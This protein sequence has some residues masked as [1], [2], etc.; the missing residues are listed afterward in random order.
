MKKIIRLTERDLTRIVRRVLNE[1]PMTNP[2]EE[3]PT[4]PMQEIPSNIPNSIHSDID[5]LYEKRDELAKEF[6][7]LE[8]RSGGLM[9]RLK[10]KVGDKMGELEDSAK[11][12]IEEIRVNVLMILDDI[13][14]KLQSL[15]LNAKKRKEE[16]M[17]R[18]HKERLEREIDIYEKSIQDIKDKKIITA[19]DLQNLKDI[20]SI[21]GIYITMIGSIIARFIYMHN[22]ESNSEI[23]PHLRD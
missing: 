13:K 21:S 16:R 9:G 8:R 1:E 4:L 20:L 5:D 2:E 10:N 18:R 23:N 14:R 12:E 11:E 7:K 22:D 15:K 19:R 6:M 17:N 3:M